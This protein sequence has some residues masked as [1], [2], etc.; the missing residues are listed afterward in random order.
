MLFDRKEDLLSTI[1]ANR[2]WANRFTTIAH[3][4]SRNGSLTETV[5]Q[6][7]FSFSREDAIKTVPT[8]DSVMTSAIDGLSSGGDSERTSETTASNRRIHQDIAGIQNSLNPQ[9]NSTFLMSELAKSV[10]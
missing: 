2:Q 1:Q 7:S 10:Q 9:E 8:T 6:F 4:V 5:L 3:S